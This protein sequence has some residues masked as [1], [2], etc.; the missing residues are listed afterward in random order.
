[1]GEPVEQRRGHLGIAEH[2]RSFAEAEVGGD[3]HAGL[4]IELGEQVEQQRPA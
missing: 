4:L 2:T 3:D 1:M